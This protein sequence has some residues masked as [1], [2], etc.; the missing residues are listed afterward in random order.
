MGW[1]WRGR[2]GK[3]KTKISLYESSKRAAVAL[4][5]RYR[6][7]RNPETGA[8]RAGYAARTP[9]AARGAIARAHSLSRSET[10]K[11]VCVCS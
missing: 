8:D 7:K 11:V 2:W 3:V 5:Q 4:S 9:A 6:Y 10:G 1:G